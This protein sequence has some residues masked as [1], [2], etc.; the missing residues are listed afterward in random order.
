MTPTESGSDYEFPE[1]LGSLH[2][3]ALSTVEVQTF[4][5]EVTRLAAQLVEPPASCGITTHYDGRVVTAAT[6]DERASL[7]DEEQYGAGDGPCLTAMRTG[8]H[9]Q[10]PDLDHETRWPVFVE[11]AR[12]HGV[13]SILAMP[14]GI[15]GERRGALNIY[16]F[17]RPDSFNEEEFQRAQVFAAQASTALTLTVRQIEKDQH[18][19][20]L[21]DALQSRSV[22]DQALGILMA[23]QRCSAENAFALL[24]QHSQN[25]NKR[26]RDVARELIER[27]TGMAPTKPVPFRR[28]GDTAR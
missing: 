9:Q 6:S 5:E 13:R 1:L 4:L 27:H 7:I 15:H 19:S 11:S 18:A 8:E 12:G 14:L 25:H 2:S 23:Q 24:R 21:E 22:I 20:Q 16:G 26:L 10:I 17:D 28:S 3:L